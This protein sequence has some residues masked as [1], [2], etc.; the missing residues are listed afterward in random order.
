MIRKMALTGCLLAGCFWCLTL[1]A[2]ADSAQKVPPVKVFK[3]AA[4]LHALMIG[5]GRQFEAITDLLADKNARN[6]S[7]KLAERAELLAELGNVNTFHR[8]ESDYV[9]WAGELRETA[10]ELAR[11]AKKRKD[12]AE[13]RMQDLY[14]Q[15]KAT[16]I[17]CHDE[18]Q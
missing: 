12:A 10:L 15:L 11:E 3:P 18:Y 13:G 9:G 14:K 2:R 8:T 4:S 5:Q 17:A 16:C 7:G 1:A 6:R